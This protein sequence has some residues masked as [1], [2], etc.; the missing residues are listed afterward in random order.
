MRSERFIEN[1]IIRNRHQLG[2]PDSVFIRRSRIGRGFGIVDVALFPLRGRHRIVLIEVKQGTAQDATSKVVGQLLMYYAGALELGLRGIRHMRE[3]AVMHPRKAR[4]VS[5]KSLKTLSGGISPPDEAWRE[6]RKGRKLK[7]SQIR[8]LVG[9]DDEPSAGLKGALTR[10]AR[11]HDLRID[12]VSV[13]ARNQLTI[14]RPE[15]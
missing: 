12:V 1:N 15:V 5:Q 3:F 6:L 10:L 4:G 11:H 13:L 14:W 2:Y 7:P 8:L 9:L